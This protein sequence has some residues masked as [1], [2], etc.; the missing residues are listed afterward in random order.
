MPN[1]YQFNTIAKTTGNTISSFD[2]TPYDENVVI[3]GVIERTEAQLTDDTYEY[4]VDQFAFWM[5]KAKTEWESQFDHLPVSERKELDSVDVIAHSACGG[6]VARS[7]IQ[8]SAYSEENFSLPK[9]NNFITLGVPFRGS[10]A[11]HTLLNNDFNADPSYAFLGNAMKF[12]RDK[13]I[14]N[15]EVIKITGKSNPQV[16]GVI[17]QDMVNNELSDPKEFLKAYAPGLQA[18]QATYPFIERVDGS[19]EIAEEEFENKLLLD[20]NDGVAHSG[21]PFSNSKKPNRFANRDIEV[22]EE[23]EG[24]ITGQ[25]LIVH[26]TGRESNFR[27]QEYDQ[28][29]IQGF[30]S[31]RLH[32]DETVRHFEDGRD[33]APEPGKLWYDIIKTD[34][35]KTDINGEIASGDGSIV[36]ESSFRQFEDYPHDNIQIENFGETPHRNLAFDVRTQEFIEPIPLISEL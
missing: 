15:N 23:I 36:D 2:N 17:T 6:S 11:P 26:G 25:A 3:D 10:A 20:L 24:L 18:L 8:S 33:T 5:E 34:G 32:Y 21:E 29:I 1:T 9:V 22:T 4:S 7:Y 12:A 14:K 28:P 31:V 19:L 35:V 13:V 27:V 16:D 30:S